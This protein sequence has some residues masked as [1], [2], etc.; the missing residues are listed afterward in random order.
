MSTELKNILTT[1]RK[2][3][4]ASAEVFLLNQIKLLQKNGDLELGADKD[5][6]GLSLELRVK[7]IFENAGL[8][9]NEGRSGQ[10][11]FVVIAHENDEHKDNLVI[12][13]K[14]S[15]SPNPKLDDLRQLDDWVF[16]LSGEEKARKQGLGGGLSPISMA[17]NGMFNITERHPTPHKGVLVFNGPIGIAFKERNS[18]I[19]HPNQ[20]EFVEKRNFC[21]IGIDSLATLMKQ[22]KNNA[23]SILHATIGEYQNA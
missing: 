17:T 12:E 14:S 16:D 7:Q 6:T 18:S 8:N 3:D 11:D 5:L 22:N 15:R 2:T 23:W 1:A 10:E 4:V 19:L 9:I 21:I 13:V 20:I